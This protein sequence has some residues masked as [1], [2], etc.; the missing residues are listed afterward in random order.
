MI[1][2]WIQEDNQFVKI[3]REELSQIESDRRLWIDARRVSQDE[4]TFLQTEYKLDPELLLDVMDQDELSRIENWDDYVLSIMRLPVFTPNAEVSYSTAPVGAVIFPDKI[5]TICWTDCE[6]LKDLSANRIKGLSLSDFPAFL[7]RILARSDIMFLRYLKEIIRRVT[8]I[9]NELHEQI[10]N[11]ELIQLLNLE[12]SLTYFTTS[13]KANQLLLEKIRR[14]RI[15]KLDS[16]DQE[17]L[18]DVEIDNRQ[19]MEMADT[20]SS[21]TTGVM[22]AF[23]NVISNNMNVTMKKL[24][25]ISLVLMIMSFITSFW[26]MNIR[27]PWSTSNSWAGFFCITGLCIISGAV[28][29]IFMNL[30]P[31]KKV[32]KNKKR[33]K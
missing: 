15:L 10:E 14:T 4:I 1:N 23:A 13:L 21:I 33:K 2:Y 18:D 29:Y 26:G 8:S 17:W 22:D 24:T 27:L 3:S 30:R 5:I 7:I 28:A 16:D 19:A 6:V 31:V 9:Q 25:V 12:K 20:Y 32:K 11:A